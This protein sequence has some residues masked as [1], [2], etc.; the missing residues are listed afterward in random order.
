MNKFI[1]ISGFIIGS[2]ISLSTLG[3]SF[4]KLTKNLNTNEQTIYV[5]IVCSLISLYIPSPISLVKI[6]KNKTEKLIIN[7]V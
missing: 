6:P 7:Q 1:K 2:I 3:F 4:Y 5:G